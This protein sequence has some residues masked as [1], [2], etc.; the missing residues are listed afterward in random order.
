[1]PAVAVSEYY[2]AAGNSLN[3]CKEIYLIRPALSIEVCENHRR[4]LS[5]IRSDPA[6]RPKI[7]LTQA[8]PSAGI[9]TASTISVTAMTQE[10]IKYTDCLDSAPELG[11][12][13]KI[14]ALIRTFVNNRIAE[15]YQDK[16]GFHFGLERS[17]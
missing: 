1:M 10:A 14:V 11:I 3:F 9:V 16:N 12:W 13:A 7:T 15:G 6:G 5:K 8:K 17:E 4:P 2:G